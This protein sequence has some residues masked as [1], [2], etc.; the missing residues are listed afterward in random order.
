MTRVF[1]DKTVAALRSAGFYQTANFLELLVKCWKIINVKDKNAHIRLND[2]DRRPIYSIDDDQ[3]EFLSELTNSIRKMPGGRGPTRRH[4]LTS[5]TQFAL[6]NTLIGLVHL[7][8][9]LLQKDHHYVCLGTFQ[10]DRLEAE[11]GIYRQMS[12]GNY[13]VSVEQVLCSLQLRRL[14]LFDQL[15]TVVEQTCNSN[16]CCTSELTDVELEIVDDSIATGDQL[17]TET[18]AAL[19]YVCG[20]ISHKENFLR[21]DSQDNVGIESE[22]TTYVSRGKLSFPSEPLYA[23]AK[24]CLYIFNSLR[25]TNSSTSRCSKRISRLFICLGDIFPCNFLGKLSAIA[26]RLTN[27]FFKGIT[28]SEMERLMDLS[29]GNRSDSEPDRK[30]RKLSSADSRKIL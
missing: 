20:Y 21:S 24:A 9:Y 29:G 1:N 7:A 10:S 23:Y 11:F 5:A 30:L 22:F 3:L 27:I 25:S 12:G 4:S 14:K 28:C 15:E 17:S 16:S 19:Y 2:P 6:S 26:C 13:F 18:L 8:K